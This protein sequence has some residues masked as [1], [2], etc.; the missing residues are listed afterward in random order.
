MKVILLIEDNTEIRE[1]MSEILELSGYKVITAED[2]KNGVELAIQDKPDLIVCDIMMPVLDGY[3]VIHMLQRNIETRNIPFIFITAKAERA[4]IRK[5]MELGADDYITK[6]FN[7]TEL[8]NA[9]ES[10]LRKTDL[11]KKDLAAG[12]EGINEL[13]ETAGGKDA[14]RVFANDRTISN[15][16]KKQVIYAE[17]SHPHRLYYITQGKVKAYKTNDDGKE[18]VTGLYSAGDFLGYVAL[19]EGGT[20]KE[21]TEALEETQVALIP[22]DDFEYL[23]NNN[24]EVMKKFIQLLANNVSEREQQLL[25]LAYNSLR[26][27]VADALLAIHNKYS[28]GKAEFI[29]DISRENLANVAGTAKESAIRTLSDFKEEKLIDIRQGEIVILDVKKLQNMFN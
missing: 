29:I 1:N 22:K 21:T 5:G 7:G 13:V 20:Y 12:L 24:R 10:R 3:G 6:P 28:A 27:K 26:K 19:L 16:K 11:I 14:L 15:F 17:E 2:G 4:E 9:V 25:N 23:V 8:L 18:L